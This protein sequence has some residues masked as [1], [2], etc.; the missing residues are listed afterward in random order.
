MTHGSLRRTLKRRLHQRA[1]AIAR[2]V[3]REVKA[4]LVVPPTTL[5]ALKDA[6]VPS[7][8]RSDAVKTQ[9]RLTRFH[10]DGPGRVRIGAFDVAA[11]SVDN[12]AFL[13]REIFVN[14][15]YY[16]RATRADPVIIDGGCN[17][18]MSVVFFK[19][20]YPHA[21]VLAFEPAERTF[22]LLQANVGGT[23]GVE[24]HRAA[25]GRE[26]TLVPF[27]ENDDPGL[28]RQSTRRQRLSEARETRVEQ[29]RLSEFITEG[30]DLV[31]LDVEG[32]EFAVVAELAD[33]GSIELVRELI[34]E[35]HHQVG[36]DDDSIGAFLEQLRTLGF[37]FQ[38]S[39]K[40]Q[41]MYRDSLKSRFQ[42]VLVHAY[43]TNDAFHH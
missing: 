29:R 20:L 10:A 43:R 21:R 3:K 6:P 40:E 36:N 1:W 4:F 13:H 37:Q 27:Y 26:N 32:A 12:L 8:W 38:L 2:A 24:L 31:K 41:V 17:I 28:L 22:D 19:T 39:A 23:P 7:G 18:G 42:D 11:L 25:L 15:A 33:S 34:V 35:Y 5:H 9:A 30:V 14:L 16:F